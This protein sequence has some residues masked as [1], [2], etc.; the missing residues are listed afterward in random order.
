[1]RKLAIPAIATLLVTLAAAPA[2]AGGH[3]HGHHSESSKRLREAVT[4]SG[5]RDHLKAFQKIADRNDDTRA[6]GTPGFAASVSYV[7]RL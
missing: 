5:V 6:S 2:N 3:G 7:K 4:V 1:L